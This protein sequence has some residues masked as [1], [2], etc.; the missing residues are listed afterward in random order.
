MTWDELKE[1]AKKIGL[2]TEQRMIRVPHNEKYFIFLER[3]DIFVEYPEHGEVRELWLCRARTPNQ[4]LAI[5]K[6][7]Q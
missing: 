4:M 6:A 2:H 3:G 7:L 5:M 1:E